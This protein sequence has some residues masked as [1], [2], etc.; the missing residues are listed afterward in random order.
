MKIPAF[1]LVILCC[2]RLL[3]ILLEKAMGLV[4]YLI[5]LTTGAIHVYE[6]KSHS[7]GQT[8]QQDRDSNHTVP[9]FSI[10]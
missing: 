4:A 2:L 1:K 9:P 8:D 7:P 3:R 6:A 5:G 10:D